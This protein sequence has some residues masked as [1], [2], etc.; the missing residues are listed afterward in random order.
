MPVSGPFGRF[1]YGLGADPSAARFRPGLAPR[2]LA[3]GDYKRDP[4]TGDLLRGTVAQ[5]RVIIALTT[6]RGSMPSA[7]EVGSVVPGLDR[8]D[9]RLELTVLRDAERALRDPIADGSISLDDVEVSV[10]G[11]TLYRVV[12]WTDLSTGEQSRTPL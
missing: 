7:R 11:G 8:D 12:V 5:Q 10:E 3:G 2:S 1:R 6:L 9:G 4:E